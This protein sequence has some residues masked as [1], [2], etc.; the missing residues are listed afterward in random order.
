MIIFGFRHFGKVDEIEGLGHV[1]TRFFHIWFI[2]LIPF[3]S[4]FV[5]G[6]EGGQLQGMGIPM[7]GKSVLAA[8]VRCGLFFALLGLVALTVFGGLGLVSAVPAL[9]HKAGNKQLTA[10]LLSVASGGG[11]CLGACASVVA[12]WGFNK[13]VGRASLERRATL[14]RLT[15]LQGAS[16]G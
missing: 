11:G 6:E 7:S 3:G 14:L 8:Y 15:G 12:W 16:P 5:L 13:L 9:M 1:R 4:V 10:L 2:P